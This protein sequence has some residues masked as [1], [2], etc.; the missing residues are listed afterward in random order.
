MRRPL[1]SALSRNPSPC[2]KIVVPCCSA[3]KSR[4]HFARA[5]GP[6]FPRVLETSACKGV[7]MKEEDTP[8][9]KVGSFLGPFSAP[10]GV[11]GGPFRVQASR[12]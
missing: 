2:F 11:E 10:G 7:R 6:R 1:C 5:Q 3:K 12:V 8:Q 4:S 9:V